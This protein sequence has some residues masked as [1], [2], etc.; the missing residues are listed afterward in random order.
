[1]TDTK[2]TI[3]AAK[4][5]RR[6]ELAKLALGAGV[7]ASVGP[8][9]SRNAAAAGVV[10]VYAWSDYI[11]QDMIESFKKE[12]G[13]DIE[14]SKYGS[15]DEVFNKLKASG[16]KGFD[17]VMPTTNEGTQ[18][19]DAGGLLQPLDESKVN[20]DAIYPSIYEQSIDL[21][22]TYRGKRYI[23]PF[24]WGT[25]GITYDSEAFKTSYGELSM[26]DL[27]RPEMVGKATVRQKSALIAIGRT[28][29]AEGKLQSNGMLDAYKD[30]ETSRKIFEQILPIAIEWKKNVKKFWNSADDTYNAFNQDGCV[31]GLTWDGP[32]IKL[33]Q[34]TNGR[35]KYLMPKEGG[36][37]WLDGMSIPT[38]AENVEGAYAFINHMYRADMGASMANQAGYNSVVAEAVNLLKPEAKTAFEAA[39]PAGAVDNL[40][41]WP[42]ITPWFNPVRAEYVEKYT[43]A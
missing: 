17:L 41:W 3:D 27:W 26:G 39:Y 37:A 33:G 8:W 21:G 9:I 12:T 5:W 23:L 19:Y 34:T 38:G 14:L 43:A 10:K 15:N 30:E 24:N 35:I 6:R 18:W 7:A 40:W 25:E 1:M 22:G 28:L 20:I 31:I 29:D 11:Y 42:I 13:L 36:F 4:T 16:G 2:N 32:G